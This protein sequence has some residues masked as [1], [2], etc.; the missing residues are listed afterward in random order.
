M[1]K[2]FINFVGRMKSTIIYYL[3]RKNPRRSG[4]LNPTIIWTL[5]LYL[6]VVSMVYT[7]IEKGMGVRKFTKENFFLSIV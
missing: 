1:H 3:A 5:R 6:V 2:I 7:P 4:S